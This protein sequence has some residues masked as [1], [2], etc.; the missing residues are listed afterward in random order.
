MGFSY[1]LS[2]VTVPF[3]KARKDVNKVRKWY[4]MW[5]IF[6]DGASEQWT[7]E[8]HL[9]AALVNAVLAALFVIEHEAV[10]WERSAPYANEL[11]TGPLIKF[12]E[13][14]KL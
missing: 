12:L 10:S 9:S 8:N 5:C 13:R 6:Q 11:L 1:A 2:F 7:F 3:L 4:F 14:R